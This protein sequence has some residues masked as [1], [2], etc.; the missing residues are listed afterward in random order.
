[1]NQ[2]LLIIV[3]P[4]AVG[5]TSLSIYLAKQFQG[6]IVSGDS[7]QIYRGMDIGT[8][9]A[10]RSERA[11][12]PHHLIDLFSPAQSFSVEMYQR[13]ARQKIQ[14]IHSRGKLPIL[15]GGTGLYIEAVTFNYQVPPASQDPSLRRTFKEVAQKEGNQVL[16]QRLAQVDPKSA[17]RIHPN[18]RKR[19]IRALEVYELTGKPFSA[20]RQKKQPYY[21]QMLWIGLTM[22]RDQLY[23]RINQRV[24]QMIE[25]GF[26]EEVKTLKNKGYHTNLTSMQAIGYKEILSY[27]EGE[28]SFEEAVGLIKRAT[29]KYAKRQFT[30]FRKNSDIHWFDMTKNEV[31]KE[32]QQ[33]VAGK[34]IIGRE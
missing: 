13:I 3:G 5:K 17:E 32:I 24:D 16:H 28:C 1:M 26:V 4:T 29:R 22:P 31:Y 33:F 19:L 34:F 15:V 10:T 2:P 11:E 7:M 8:A 14:D 25:Q 20:Y 21:D 9:K 6:E 23:E 12:I 18:D 27:L 30:W